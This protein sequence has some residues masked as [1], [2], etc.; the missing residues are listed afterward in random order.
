MPS[1]AVAR[2]TRDLQ[3]RQELAGHR[4][5]RPRPDDRQATPQ[6]RVGPDQGRGQAA[7][8]TPG[9]RGGRRPTPRRPQADRGRAAGPVVRM[10]PGRAAH[11]A[12]DGRQ[13][14]PRHGLVHP[15]AARQAPRHPAGRRHAGPLRNL[16][17]VGSRRT[18]VPL[19]S[20]APRPRSTSSSELR[21]ARPGPATAS[22]SLGGDWPAES[23][24]WSWPRTF[25]RTSAERC[26]FVRS[27]ALS[28]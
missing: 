10:A 24:Q 20:P 13:L 28:C 12:A 8:G 17:S 26:R 21:P 15:A 3:A 4:L 16:S 14:P 19:R 25:G 5:P 6:E 27:P 11:R 7:R 2:G 23:R 9:D 22:G 1:G 18:P